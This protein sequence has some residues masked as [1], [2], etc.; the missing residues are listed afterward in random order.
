ME[1][2][3]II[4]GGANNRFL[5]QLTADATG[6]PVLAGP[7]EATAIGNILIQARGLGY[8]ESL[9]EMRKI[10]TDSFEAIQYLPSKTLNWHET[11]QRFVKIVKAEK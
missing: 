4:G 1:K 3:H 11:Y 6:L 9:A 2:I 10:V 5:C 7:V 8:V